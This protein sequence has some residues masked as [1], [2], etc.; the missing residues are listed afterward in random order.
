M[1]KTEM[2]GFGGNGSLDAGSLSFKILARA[3][4]LMS[5]KTDHSR[6]N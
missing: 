1:E 5:Q 4:I 6:T 2:L 3:S